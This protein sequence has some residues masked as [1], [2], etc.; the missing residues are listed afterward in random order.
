M[1]SAAE[2]DNNTDIYNSL[3][4]AAFCLITYVWVVMYVP[5]TR[6]VAL[7]RPMDQL[8]EDTSKTSELNEPEVEEVE[9]VDERT[10][11]LHR[12]RERQRRR[13]SFAGFNA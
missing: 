8:F 5:E 12:E 9:E 4:Y 6:G 7:G 2:N 1:S 3:V 11:L 13:S 10:A